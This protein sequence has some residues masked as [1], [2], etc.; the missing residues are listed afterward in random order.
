MSSVDTA[1]WVGKK[2]NDAQAITVIQ[3]IDKCRLEDADVGRLTMTEEERH[4]ARAEEMKVLFAKLGDGTDS[5][6]KGCFMAS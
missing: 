3:K 6:V 4:D 5:H 2:D 1:T